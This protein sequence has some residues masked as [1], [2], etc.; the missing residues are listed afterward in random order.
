MDIQ[1][2]DHVNLRTTRLDEMIEWYSNILDMS[3]GDR[4]PF[5]FPGAWCYRH[6]HAL[7]HLVGVDHEGGTE[8]LK[9]EHFAL[10]ATGLKEFLAHL[11]KH[12]VRTRIGRLP[13]FRHVQVNIWDPDGNHIHVDFSPEEGDALNISDRPK[14]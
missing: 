8:N 10:S 7:V 13:E 11:E 14:A 12:N 6:G 9:L 1:R 5:S 4:P 3:P 2:L